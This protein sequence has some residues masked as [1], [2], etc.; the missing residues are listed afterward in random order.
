MRES[1][2]LGLM[3]VGVA[4]WHGAAAQTLREAVEGAW[5]LN[6]Q[7]QALEARRNEFIARRA[8][9]S[10]FFPAPPAITLSHATDQLIENKRQRVTE[11]E[12]STPLW[13]PGEGTATERVAETELVRTDAQLALARLTVTGTVRDAVYK[14]ALADSEAK[15][16][17]RR[18]ENAC[19][20]EADVARRM[21][22]GEVAALERDLARSELFA[23]Q[24][25]L[26]EQ[27]AQAATARI[28]LLSLTGLQAPPKEFAEPLAARSDIRRHPRLQ[29]AERSMGVAQA[30]LRLVGIA[31]RD[32]PEIGLFVSR[33]R[34]T[35]GTQYDT[36]VGLRLRV[37]FATE[38]RNAPR[39]AAAQADLTAARAE[40][41]A[42]EREI[43]VELAAAQQMLAAAEAETPLVERRLQAVRASAAR[44]QR[45]YNAGEIGLIEVLR[46]RVA[47]FEAEL[48]QAQNRLAVGQAR[49]RVN[50][51]LGVVP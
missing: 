16:A 44:L 14:Y 27:Q 37:P 31:T 12:V 40:Y 23:A 42:A 32:S 35:F 48:A 24:A 11:G 17:Q 26:R 41:A 21:R 5:A 7:I 2:L 33:N 51:A 46:A 29:A 19:A 10:A 6:P 39:R 4:A 49:A 8:S 18:V 34:D 1:L 38:A 36:T 9:A 25:N 22:A 30:S 43:R 3:L 28:A 20:L 47:V 15:L 50:Q 45:S 13:L